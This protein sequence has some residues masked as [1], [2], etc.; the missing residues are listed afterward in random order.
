MSLAITIEEIARLAEVS[1]S[2]VSRVLNNHP[3]VRPAVRDKVLRVVRE[4][5][6]TPNAAARSLASNR[7]YAIS[8]V[9]PG[10]TGAIFADPFFPQVIQGISETCNGAGYVL[11]LAM[12][13]AEMEQTF[14]NRMVGGKHFDG[15]IMLS[16][17]VDDPLLPRLMR[18][19][20]PLVLIGRHPYLE[21]LS[22]VDSENFEG[23]REATAHLIGLG[24]RR[25]A[26]ITGRLTMQ[27]GVDRR[28]GYEQA[29]L[30]AGLPL[31]P[32]L[33]VEGDYT[34]ERGYRAMRQLLALPRPPT[35]VFAGSDATAF[36]AQRAIHEAGLRMPEDV[37][38]V[39]FDDVPAAA[40][41]NPPLTTMRQPSAE[42]GEQ[43]VRV[44]LA[45]I[46]DPGRHPTAVRLPTALVVRAS[47]GA[48]SP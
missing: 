42:L 44:L 36:G 39:G 45:H 10:S 28:D 17:D 34:Q 15:V 35:A 12:L 7:S 20:T 27:S 2:T 47:C 41:A 1:R 46:E 9:I 33:I 18:E 40:Y 37:A 5:N 26:T 14:Y 43:A 13:T 4:Q 3:N 19:G 25:V 8:L 30:A 31:D 21:G 22:T 48:A 11:M 29:L 6:Y 24:H 38:L 32:A 16:S 23:A